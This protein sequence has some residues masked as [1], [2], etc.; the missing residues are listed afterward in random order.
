VKLFRHKFV[1]H[2]VNYDIA[3]DWSR[4]AIVASL[5]LGT[6]ACTEVGRKEFKKGRIQDHSRI[7]ACVSLIAPPPEGMLRDVVAG[8]SPRIKREAWPTSFR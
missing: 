5:R 1:L 2:D 4:G 8:I 6:G 7:L 3:Y